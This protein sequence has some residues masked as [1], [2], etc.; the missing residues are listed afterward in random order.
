MVFAERGGV[1]FWMLVIS[2]AI[3]LGG[4]C[5]FVAGVASLE[6]PQPGNEPSQTDA[7]L[8]NGSTIVEERRDPIAG[9]GRRTSD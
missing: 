4:V 9:S 5:A 6:S 3:F 2:P 1:R 7:P 8:R